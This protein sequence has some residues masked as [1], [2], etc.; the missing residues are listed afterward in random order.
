MQAKKLL[1]LTLVAIVSGTLFTNAQTSMDTGGR[2]RPE[3]SRFSVAGQ[4]LYN[5][6]PYP[7][8]IGV[9][10]DLKL[11]INSYHKNADAFNEYVIGVRGLHTFPTDGPFYGSF[12]KGVFNNVSTV[13]GL[14]G[15]RFNFGAPYAFHGDYKRD[16]GGWFIELAGGGAYYR[17]SKTLRPAVMPMVGYAVARDLDIIASYTG[18]WNHTKGRSPV[19]AFG[20]GLMY[21]F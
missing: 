13:I 11:Y 15:Y 18:T 20:M 6:Y 8:H 12:D 19:A 7:G 17:F 9:S 14:A 3:S 10:L 5:G 2:F 4:G 1:F 16:S 21:N